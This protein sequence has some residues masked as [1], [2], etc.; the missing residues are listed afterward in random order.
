MNPLRSA[1]LVS[2]LL[3]LGC[4]SPSVSVVRFHSPPGSQLVFQD[5]AG[6]AV[7]SVVFPGNVEFAQFSAGGDEGQRPFSGK[8]RVNGLVEE[9]RIPAEARALLVEGEGGVDIPVKGYYR[10]FERAGGVEESVSTYP[11]EV[12][13]SQLLLIMNGKAVTVSAETGGVVDLIVGL[14]LEVEKAAGSE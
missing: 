3:A 8:L 1:L 4:S 5:E 14:D 12:S 10:V 13:K 11:V 6:L 2:V 9:E 7:G